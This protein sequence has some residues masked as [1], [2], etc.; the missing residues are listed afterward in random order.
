MLVENYLPEDLQTEDGM[1]LKEGSSVTVPENHFFV[2]GDN[3]SASSDSRT[4]G[5][6]TKDK[7][8]GR[9]WITYWPP[10]KFG[11]IEGVSY[12]FSQEVTAL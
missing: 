7:I 2:M 6:I 9:A 3:R 8:T 4:W 11:L 12:S 10:P 1:F 5:F